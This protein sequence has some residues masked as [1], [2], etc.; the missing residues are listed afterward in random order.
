MP[1]RKLTL[2]TDP[3]SEEERRNLEPARRPEQRKSLLRHAVEGASQ[4][5]AEWPTTLSFGLIPSIK[6]KEFLQER[7]NRDTLEQRMKKEL[8]S[9]KK[10][11]NF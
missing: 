8:E 3:L 2:S 4:H 7:K 1:K 6:S 10:G 5:V 11:A 9:V